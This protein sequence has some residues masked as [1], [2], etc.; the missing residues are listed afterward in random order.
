MFAG[1]L[2]PYG[3]VDFF[4]NILPIEQAKTRFFLKGSSGSGKSTFI[5]K[6]AT[7]FEA[8]GFKTE[9]FHC[10]NDAN[11]LDAVSV[12]TR[13]L[14]IIDATLPHCHDPEIPASVDKIIDFAQFLNADKVNQHLSELKSLLHVKKKQSSFVQKELFK[15][16]Q[17]YNAEIDSEREMGFKAERALFL[18]A[19]TPDGF[20]TFADDF[21]ADC[22]VYDNLPDCEILFGDQLKI[23]FLSPF[24]PDLLEYLYFPDEKT[25]YRISK[26]PN[27]ELFEKELNN[28]ID[29]MQ[30]AKAI[31]ARIEEIYAEAM[32]FEK[33]NVMVENIL[34]YLVSMN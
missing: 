18:S 12:P 3:F 6:A 29:T 14:S 33:L 11:S 10:A 19:I 27:C 7:E 15:L 32:D 5:K 30:K 24:N 17:V 28:T 26:M 21:F 1:A 8:R 22:K 23:G 4:H 34:R 31:H 13:G 25:A 2:T 16:G 20:V 9:R